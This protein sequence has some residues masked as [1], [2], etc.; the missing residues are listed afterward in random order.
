MIAGVADSPVLVDHPERKRTP[1]RPS[2]G[3]TVG[4]AVDEHR[5]GACLKVGGEVDGGYGLA[6]APFEA[7][8]RDD[9]VA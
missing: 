2:G 1:L 5:G 8:H 6:H 3:A 7:R 4:V 9:R